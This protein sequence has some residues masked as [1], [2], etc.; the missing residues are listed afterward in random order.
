MMVPTLGPGTE[1]S[2]MCLRPRHVPKSG[3]LG[4]AP[5]LHH[6]QKCLLRHRLLCYVYLDRVADFVFAFSFFAKPEY[7]FVPDMRLVLAKLGPHLVLN[8]MDCI[9]SSI[10]MPI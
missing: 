5:C 2:G 9:D 8:G 3:K 1:N 10:D 6:L 4:T 7:A